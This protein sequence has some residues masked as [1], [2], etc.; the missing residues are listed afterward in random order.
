MNLTDFSALI[1][2]VTGC[3]SLLTV[4]YLLAVKITRIELKV[5]T[6]WDFQL[7]RGTA[8]GVGKGFMTLNSPVAIDTAALSW[9]SPLRDDLTAFYKK[10][11]YSLSQQDLASE[12]ERQWGER[13]MRDICIPRGVSHGVCLMI[14]IAVARGA[15]TINLN[16]DAT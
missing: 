2:A 6:L 16:G 7:R 8:E 13:I 5:D 4:V 15:S 9:L 10:H 12:I 3:A 1:G 11:G 14:A